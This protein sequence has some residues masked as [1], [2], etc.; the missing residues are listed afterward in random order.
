MKGMRN[1]RGIG[2]RLLDVI[3][4]DWKETPKEKE[5]KEDCISPPNC[6]LIE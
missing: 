1:V 3:L 5:K 2:Q 6:P 4:V